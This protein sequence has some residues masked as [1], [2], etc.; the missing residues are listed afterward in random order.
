MKNKGFTLIELLVVIAIIGIL[1]SIAIP[2]FAEYRQ[3]AF[4]AAARSDLRN[5]MT[6]QE[7][8]YI[9]ADA[10]TAD[11]A[12]LP[13]FEGVSEGVN[14]VLGTAAVNGEA[15]QAW[16]GT[17]THPKGTQG[18][19]YCYNSTVDTVLRDSGC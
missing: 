9:D 18:N 1:A 17:S 15:D 19:L 12:A 5:V 14:L 13:G 8:R 11:I 7:A 4:A 16:N 2:Q 3:R 10:Y 6:A